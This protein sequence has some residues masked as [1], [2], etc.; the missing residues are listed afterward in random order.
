LG[1]KKFIHGD[2]ITVNDFYFYEDMS[3]FL[4]YDETMFEGLDNVKE[5]LNRFKEI[6]EIKAYLQS[7]KFKER[8]INNGPVANWF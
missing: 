6:P 1:N 7:N 3:H 2:S 8:P 4:I 5:Y